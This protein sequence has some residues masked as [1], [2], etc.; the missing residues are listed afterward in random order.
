MKF[1]IPK[2]R[3]P[4]MAIWC[5]F[6]KSQLFG[7]KKKLRWS[8]KWAMGWK[9]WK[10][11]WLPHRPSWVPSPWFYHLH[12]FDIKF[13]SR[14]HIDHQIWCYFSLSTPDH[15]IMSSINDT[16]KFE[17]PNNEPTLS[18]QLIKIVK[19]SP[20]HIF[21]P[22]HSSCGSAPKWWRPLNSWGRAPTEGERT[23]PEPTSAQSL[24]S[25]ERRTEPS[26]RKKSKELK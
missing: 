4:T 25:K 20:F 3:F 6:T 11:L 12:L 19:I 7:K 24:V 2:N 21:R 23:S 15:S 16:D 18:S 14:Q 13:P 17:I 26:L 9:I 1:K 10:T 5:W 22:C 8:K